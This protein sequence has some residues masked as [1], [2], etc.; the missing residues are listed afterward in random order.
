[1]QNAERLYQRAGKQRRAVERVRPLLEAAEAE[2]G[3]IHAV[4]MLLSL[5]FG[6]SHIRYQLRVL[7]GIVGQESFMGGV[8]HTTMMTA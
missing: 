4:Q 8:L 2:V 5:D 6:T 3:S 7:F 1:M